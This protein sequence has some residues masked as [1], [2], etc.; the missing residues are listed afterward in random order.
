M[1]YISGASKK[2]LGGMPLRIAHQEKRKVEFSS[3]KEAVEALMPLGMWKESMISCYAN[4]FHYDE[5]Q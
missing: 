2:Q 1:S 5:L 4:A 3:M